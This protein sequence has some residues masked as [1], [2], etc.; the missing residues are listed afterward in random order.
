MGIPAYIEH[1]YGVRRYHGTN[2]DVVQDII[3]QGQ[4]DAF[5]VVDLGN[6][7]RKLEMWQNYLPRVEP[8]Y[9]VKCNPDPV[10]LAT[11]H[12]LGVKFDCASRG[13]IEM[14]LSLP[15]AQPTD[16]I[17]ANCCKAKSMIAFAAEH[18]VDY[19]T[20][21]NEFELYK[22][23]EVH[24]H[25]KL[26][27]RIITDDS[28]A[29]CRL[30]TKFGAPLDDVRQL[31]ASA[32][33]L[34]LDVVG[35]SFHVGSG[36][37]H[38]SAFT[39]SLESAKQVFEWAEDFGYHMNFLDIGGGFPGS[40]DGPLTFGGVAKAVGPMLDAMFP[41]ARVIAEPGRY[42]ASSTCT[43]ATQIIAK[44]K[45]NH[46][47]DPVATD[48]TTEEQEARRERADIVRQDDFLYYVNDGVYGSFN[49]LMFDHAAAAPKALHERTHEKYR[50][51][52]FGP[53]CDGLDTIGRNKLLP[54]ME[55]G[56][57]M[58]FES[59]GAYTNAASS[60]F[61][62]FQKPAMYYVITETA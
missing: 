28:N 39:K 44:R 43:I 5:F 51:T 18:S 30:S 56:D 22:I 41:H 10:I 55:I 54:M 6:L 35:V 62:G 34:G 60:C 17:Y 49:N 32:Q 58:Y 40:D 19:M 21:D 29:V 14:V 24:P 31:L 2:L 48:A 9:A 20:F 3:N 52:V 36:Q 8:F 7:V 53:T 61:N 42:F 11:L 57:W 23:K 38:A 37:C 25:A 16:I 50:S 12:S 33:N 15:N 26:V 1:Q 46:G 45:V 13:E 47:A 59:M 4:Q 27:L